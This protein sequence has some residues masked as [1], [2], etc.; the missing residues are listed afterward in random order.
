MPNPRLSTPNS[1]QKHRLTILR[2]AV[3]G[4]LGGTTGANKNMMIIFD[5]QLKSRKL[6][7]I[8]CAFSATRDAA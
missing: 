6:L 1:K 3:K 4:L 2:L 7:D 8:I 5:A